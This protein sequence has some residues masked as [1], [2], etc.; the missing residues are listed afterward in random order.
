MRRSLVIKRILRAAERDWVF[1]LVVV[2]MAITLLPAAWIMKT[3]RKDVTLFSMWLEEELLE[4][5]QSHRSQKGSLT[6]QCELLDI[7]FCSLQMV[8]IG[9]SIR[10]M[11]CMNASPTLGAIAYWQASQI[12]RLRRPLIKDIMALRKSRTFRQ[13]LISSINEYRKSIYDQSNPSGR[14]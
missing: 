12:I 3:P 1:R 8:K 11:P 10:L 5:H 4:F 2:I 6:S 14:R 7:W 9:A 13:H